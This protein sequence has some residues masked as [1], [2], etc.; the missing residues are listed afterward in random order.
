MLLP[1]LPHGAVE[2][3]PSSKIPSSALYLPILAPGFTDRHPLRLLSL[4]HVTQRERTA[5]ST[6]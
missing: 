3:C 4:R 5:L 6:A 2:G 1:S